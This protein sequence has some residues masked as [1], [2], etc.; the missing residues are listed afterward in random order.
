MEQEAQCDYFERSLNAEDGQKILFGRLQLNGQR[1]LVMIGQ[2]LLQCKHHT[3]GYDCQ[4][5]HVLKRRAI[6]QTVKVS[7]LEFV[8]KNKL[9]FYKKKGYPHSMIMRAYLRITLSSENMNKARVFLHGMPI[10]LM[11]R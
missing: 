5:H 6:Q 2:M 3:I 11:K 7:Q 8:I 10:R 4:Q 1:R 9:C